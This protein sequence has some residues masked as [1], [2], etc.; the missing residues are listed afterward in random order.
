MWLYCLFP[1]LLDAIM[2]GGIAGVLGLD[3]DKDNHPLVDIDV[4]GD[5][6]E[7]F[8]QANPTPGMSAHV[9]TCKDGDG[10]VI[11]DNF[12]GKGTPCWLAKDKNGNYR[13][14]DG[15]SLALKFT[16]VPVKLGDVLP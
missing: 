12:D 16:A 3:V 7:T 9:D 13:F 6:I 11:H 4:D 8:W 10:T 5:G 1:S 14:V 2:L 15:I